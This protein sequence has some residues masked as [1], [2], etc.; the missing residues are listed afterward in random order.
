M[1][2][3]NAKRNTGPP[4]LELGNDWDKF[5]RRFEAYGERAGLQPAL[6]RAEL[7]MNKRDMK[8]RLC[9]AMKEEKEHKE[10]KKKRKQKMNY[11]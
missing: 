4:V 8:V 5:R 7:V 9:S 1:T 2:D 11:K 6:K 10:E 3:Q